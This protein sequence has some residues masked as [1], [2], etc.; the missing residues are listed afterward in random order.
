[1]SAVLPVKE[2]EVH[3]IMLVKISTYLDTYGK[4]DSAILRNVLST[5][6]V[7]RWR[8]LH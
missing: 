4:S 2:K 5:C 7:I 3:S 1:M 6:S 8:H